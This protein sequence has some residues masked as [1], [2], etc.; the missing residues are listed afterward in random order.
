MKL[1]DVDPDIEFDLSLAGGFAQEPNRQR[2]VE[3]NSNSEERHMPGNHN[4]KEHGRKGDSSTVKG[5]DQTEWAAGLSRDGYAEND[6]MT[7]TDFNDP[8]DR[9]LIGIAKQAPT[10]LLPV[11]KESRAARLST[12]NR[13][14]IKDSDKCPLCVANN[15][16]RKVPV[17]PNCHCDV[18]TNEVETGVA[19]N[20]SRLLDVIRAADGFIDID[21]IGAD[22]EVPAAIQLNPETV[23]VFDPENVRFADLARWLEQMQPYLEA[24]DQYVSIVVDDDTDEALTQIEETLSQIAEN[25]EQLAEA[26]R[27]KK[28]WFGIAQAVV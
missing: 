19:D 11:R 7:S 13:A 21:V 25:P 14:I 20:S 27:N 3:D 17:H 2:I 5:T 22:A 15:D 9:T 28:L 12:L 1:I 16:P 8:R 6:I 26:I 18:V 24:S 4:Q 23:A 10:K